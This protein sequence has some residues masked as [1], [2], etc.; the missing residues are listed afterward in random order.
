[1]T[2]FGDHLKRF[3]QSSNDPGRFNRRLTQERLGELI[4]DELGDL[5]F[6]GS[7]ISLWERGESRISAEDRNVLIAIVRVLHQCGGLKTSAEADQ[8]LQAGRYMVLDDDETRGIFHTT[9]EEYE[10]DVSNPQTDSSQSTQPEWLLKLLS[11]SRNEMDAL[12]ARAKAEGPDPYWPRVLAG[13]IRKVTDPF[14]L[15]FTM[16]LWLAIWF[17]TKWL[18]GP[19]L[20][21]PF[22]SH[23]S[24]FVA[25]S[26]YAAGSLI[27][28]LLIGCLINTKDNLYW[29]RQPGVRSWLL[30]L[31][32]YQGAAIGFNVGYFLVFPGSLLLYYLGLPHTAWLE[33]LAAT[34]C[35]VLGTMAA[36]VVPHNLWRAYGQLTLKDGVIFFVV[37][38]I[39]PLWAFLFLEFYS[40][41]LNPALGIVVILLAMSGVMLI[42]RRSSRKQTA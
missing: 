21:F 17:L 18:V 11:I 15:S 25:L 40:T 37:A 10:D 1:V 29:N 28:P 26:I 20:R 22:T 30:R 3:R 4:G 33:I 32:T 6:S 13:L 31:Y 39:G 23:V 34:V 42:A 27:I 14:S 41:L 7:A 36:R 12:I 16:I 19:S 2:A 8:L 35:L 38:L 24:A 5:G 9:P